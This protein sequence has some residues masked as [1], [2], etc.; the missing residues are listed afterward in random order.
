MPGLRTWALVGLLLL[1][2][3]GRG[4]SAYN[5]I[6]ITGA[7][8]ASDFR[9]GD[10]DGRERTLADFRG[11]YVLLFFGYTQCPDV[12]PTA[13]SRAAEVRKLLGTDGDKL[14][15]IFVT[16]DPERDTAEMVKQYTAAFDPSFLG[17]R[18]DL[19][20]TRKVAKEFR[21]FYQKVPSGGSYTMDHTAFTYVFDAQGRP[22]LILRHDQTADQYASDLHLLTSR[23]NAG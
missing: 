12:C 17:L 7:D 23:G 6:D 3:C 5:G 18:T 21:V 20:G 13:L 11:K 15:V 4:I 8:F 1:S 19:E 9:L 16:L 10:S 22:R 14:Q 2:A